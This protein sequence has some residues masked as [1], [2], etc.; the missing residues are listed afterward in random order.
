MLVMQTCKTVPPD[1]VETIDCFKDV[2]EYKGK[3]A[4]IV[5]VFD[6]KHG[7]QELRTKWLRNH[8]Q[9]FEIVDYAQNSADLDSWMQL[10]L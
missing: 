4:D 1:V 2:Q 7:V 9:D 8:R 10:K 5:V 3:R 6:H